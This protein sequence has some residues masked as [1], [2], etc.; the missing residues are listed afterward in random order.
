[1]PR[2]WAIPLL[3]AMFFLAGL[4]VASADDAEGGPEEQDPNTIVWTEPQDVTDL[5]VVHHNETLIVRGVQIALDK[6]FHVQVDGRLIL[7]SLP[8][9]PAGF[10]AK[11]ESGWV[12]EVYGSV[13]ANGT[14]EDPVLLDGVGGLAQASGDTVLFTTGI[15]VTEGLLWTDHVVIQNYTS[16]VKSGLNAT[17]ML[18]NTTFTSERGLGLVA[19]Q[20]QIWGWDLTFDGKA[21]SF[22]SV[23]AGRS[24]LY[25][26]TFQRNNFGIVSNGLD[27]TVHGIRIQDSEGCIRTT[28]GYFNG[29]DVECL[30]YNT[31]GIVISKPVKGARLPT[32]TFRG[33]RATTEAPNATA[34]IQVIAAPNT[35]LEDLDLGPLPTQGVYVER[36]MPAISNATFRGNGHYNVLAIDVE[37]N[38]PAG[39]IGEGESG[40]EGWLFV[41]YRF[42]ARVLGIDSVPAEGAT[43]LARHQN[44]TLA[45]RK[46]T[47]A[48]GTTSTA[49]LAIREVPPDGNVL[50]HTYDL[51]AMSRD[52]RGR[53]SRQDYVPDGDVLL[54]QLLEQAPANDTPGPSVLLVLLSVAF[55]AVAARRRR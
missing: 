49:L 31:S 21:A 51:E 43:L 17:L 1:M 16:G 52:G 14:P 42:S 25:D 23:A 38:V 46:I 40:A 2:A 41:G 55:V 30:R 45:L 3:V 24:N 20:G 22:W 15:G 29:T 6:G 11:N 12:G 13:Y 10:T 36:H 26:S 34:A 50:D 47:N 7:E 9:K 18:H 8:G 19:S 4:P 33:V 53:W 5:L 48:A 44:G 39:K 37:R 27:T 28:V 54:V 32:A 35:V